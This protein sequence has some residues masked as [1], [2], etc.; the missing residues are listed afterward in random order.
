MKD[1]NVMIIGLGLTNQ[2]AA[3]NAYTG[4]AG[5]LI[6]SYWKVMALSKIP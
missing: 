6:A 4:S 1:V 2:R 3:V 5:S